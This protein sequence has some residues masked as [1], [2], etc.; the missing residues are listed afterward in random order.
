VLGVKQN[1]KRKKSL[2]PRVV[3]FAVLVIGVYFAGSFAIDNIKKI[4]SLLPNVVGEQ[5]GQPMTERVYGTEKPSVPG[6][7]STQP[8]ESSANNNSLNSNVSDNTFALKVSEITDTQWTMKNIL[9][10]ENWMDFIT[11]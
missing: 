5:S 6:A 9:L 7:N 1:R 3:L 8:S 2:S 10:N 4:A 11:E